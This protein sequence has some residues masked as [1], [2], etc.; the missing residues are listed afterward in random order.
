MFETETE[1]QLSAG[2]RTL[3]TAE[4]TRWLKEEQVT[5]PDWSSQNPDFKSMHAQI[6]HFYFILL[7]V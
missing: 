1:A 3:N 4:A 2:R 7:L 5:V 6:S